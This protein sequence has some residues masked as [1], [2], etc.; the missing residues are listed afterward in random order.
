MI[1]GI[2][3]AFNSVVMRTRPFEICRLQ[4][5]DNYHAGFHPNEH[6]LR[7]SRE[8]ENGQLS[9]NRESNIPIG[10]DNR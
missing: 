7:L 4:Q 6:A 5:I 8:R 2:V 10:L 1:S 9:R 3:T